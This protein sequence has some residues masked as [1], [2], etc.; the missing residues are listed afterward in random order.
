MGF[1]HAG[2]GQSQLRESCLFVRST[3]GPD[4]QDPPAAGYDTYYK[5]TA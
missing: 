3:I 4:L 1:G 5:P 2:Q